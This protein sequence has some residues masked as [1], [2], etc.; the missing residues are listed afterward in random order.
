MTVRE[1]MT[2]NPY[3]ATPD[4]GLQQVAQM[5]VDFDCGAIPVVETLESFR[6]V[7]IVTDRDITC[8]VVAQGENP[9]QLT[10]RDCMSAPVLTVAHTDSVNTVLDIMETGKVRRVLVVDDR[11]R[12]CGI[13][14][15]ADVARH[16][17]ARV[18]VEVVRELSQPSAL[19]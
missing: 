17:P 8:R 9:I 16:A 4:T 10:A 15:Q 1:L 13:I 12:C 5:L 11:G 6:P 3:C 19:H 18:T 2:P 7:G 14:S